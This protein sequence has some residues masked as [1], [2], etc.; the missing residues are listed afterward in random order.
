[1]G[2]TEAVTNRLPVFVLPNFN[3]PEMLLLFRPE[4]GMNEALGGIYSEVSMTPDLVTDQL[5][6]SKFGGK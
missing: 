3:M 1:M 5:I 2:K 6:N 4:R